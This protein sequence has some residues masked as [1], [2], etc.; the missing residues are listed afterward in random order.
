[1]EVRRDRLCTI[2]TVDLHVML[3]QSLVLG[4]EDQ[5]RWALESGMVE[6][7]AQVNFLESV[8][9]GPLDSVASERITIIR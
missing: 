6:N 4:L 3:T 1:M 5:A 8:D 9:T 7:A 2:G